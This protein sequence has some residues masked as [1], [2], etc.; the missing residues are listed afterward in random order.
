[1]CMVVVA[2]VFFLVLEANQMAI[3]ANTVPTRGIHDGAV[4]TEDA[5]TFFLR[6]ENPYSADYRSMPFGGFLDGFSRGVRPNPAW[7]HHVYLP[8]HFLASL[9]FSYAL[10]H[11]TGWYDQRLV[12]I[13]AEIA[14]L[15]FIIRL[16]RGRE[17]QLFV[18]LL[19]LLNPF[20]VKF[21]VQGY[22]DIFVFSLMA[23]MLWYLQKGRWNW[24]GVMYG[25]ACASKQSAWMF[26]P[27]F[28]VYLYWKG[29][30][31]KRDWRIPALLAFGVAAFFLLP[32][33]FWDA[34]GFIDDIYRYPA[35]SLPTSYPISGFGISDV[36]VSIGFIQ[37]MWD[38]YPFIY[39]QALIAGPLL[40]VLLFL[41]R[42]RNTLTQL[43]ISAMVFSFTFWFLS[44]FFNWNYVSYLSF[45]AVA[46]LA[47]AGPPRFLNHRV[48]G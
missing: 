25:L 18:G 48:H 47:I 16:A 29:R 30:S 23:G 5:I 32:F 35:G 41:Q 21:F 38:Y 7:W 9:P 17:W 43:V 27:F 20:W 31:A 2:A 24:A 45:F 22:N 26:A 40:A 8:F 28:I 10:N 33:L 46:A 15:V 6:G 44:R 19:F 3:R 4:Q 11:L 13:L 12:Y 42:M 14:S 39:L 37:S 34:K 36:L 1:M